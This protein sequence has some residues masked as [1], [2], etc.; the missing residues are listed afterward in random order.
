VGGGEGDTFISVEKRMIIRE[1]LH[2]RCSFLRDVRVVTH[3][4]AEYSR[5]QETLFA[6]PMNS[7]VLFNLELVDG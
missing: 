4:R 3:L 7:A 2:E 1:R 6:P 5:F